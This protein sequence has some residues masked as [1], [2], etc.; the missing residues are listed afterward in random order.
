MKQLF[1]LIFVCSLCSCGNRSDS[2]SNETASN[3]SIKNTQS[4]KKVYDTAAKKDIWLDSIANIDFVK[5]TNAYIDSFSN[6]KHGIA[7]FKD[8]VSNGE[9]IIAAGYNGDKRFETYYSF[10]ID[11]NL[12]KLKI[13]DPISGARMTIDAFR[14]TLIQ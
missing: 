13:L 11:P 8:T 6:H 5:K 14:K 12:K 7:F 1:I 10:F 9:I 2:N 3:G 4:L